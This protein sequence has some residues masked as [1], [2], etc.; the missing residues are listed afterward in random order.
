MKE[1]NVSTQSELSQLGLDTFRHIRRDKYIQE[2]ITFDR[3]KNISDHSSHRL[4]R[5]THLVR[6]SKL[7]TNDSQGDLSHYASSIISLAR[8]TEQII[9]TPIDGQLI[10]NTMLDQKSTQQKIF[11]GK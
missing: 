10:H 1:Q 5:T 8:G 9:I 3:D 7:S 6:K 4:S 2:M 11:T